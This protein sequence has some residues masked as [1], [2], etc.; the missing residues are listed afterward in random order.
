MDDLK[1]K[2]QECDNL[3][4]RIKKLEEDL[5]EKNKMLNKI[6]DLDRVTKERD[7]LLV[8]LNN[9]A[10]RFEE[11]VKNQRQVSAEL[12]LSPRTLGDETDLQKI[13]EMVIKEVREEMEQKVTQELRAIETQN[14]DK[15]K[16]FEERYKVL[17]LQ[18][19]K[20]METLKQS[21]KKETEAASYTA[22][23]TKEEAVNKLIENKLNV[24]CEALLARKVHIEKLEEKLKQQENVIGE[25]RNVMAQLMTGWVAEIRDVKAK[26]ESMKDEIKKLNETGKNLRLESNALKD[27]IEK[28]K[29]IEK[30]LR[31]ESNAL[32]DEIEKLK[33]TEKNL[34]LESEALKEKEREAKQNINMLKHKY[35]VAKKTGIN[36]K[37]FAKKKDEFIQSEHK[38]LEEGYKKAIIQ[39]QKRYDEVISAHKKQMQTK[40]REL[41]SQYRERIEQMENP[42]QVQN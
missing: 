25:E 16:E 23:I 1:G 2:V 22:F 15:R 24:Y 37:E 14:R 34:R 41:D 12:N 7:L 28:L 29:E 13:R 27:E 3:K 17:L 31:L 9:Q 26:E 42:K 11:C 18:K 30:N 40:F 38:R 4:K 20:E 5:E 10:K 36:Y 8:K 21:L 19:E 39:V 6:N 32:K 35:R 33:E